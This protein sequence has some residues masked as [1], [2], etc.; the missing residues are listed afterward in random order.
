[1]FFT[2]SLIFVML[3]CLS[4]NINGLRSKPKQDMFFNQAKADILC[5]QETRWDEGNE[6]DIKKLWEGEVYVQNGSQ[7]SCG[8]ATMI[9]KGAMANVKCVHKDKKGRFIIEGKYKEV[10]LRLINIY[11]PNNESERK[12]FF[13]EVARWCNEDTIIIGDFN[14]ALTQIDVSK[15]N[16]FKNDASRR[17]LFK[18]CEEHNLTDV[19]RMWYKHKR[20]YSRKQM[21]KG[22]MKQTRIDLC[23]AAPTCVAKENKIVYVENSWSDHMKIEMLLENR[24]ELRNGGL[25]VYNASLNDD[26]TFKKKYV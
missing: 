3:H 12:E 18:L 9:K 10:N 14:V 26:E 19:W 17:V 6:K 23:L 8:V 21:V 2:L 20:E 16:V 13:E 1:M 4:L 15:N 7:K 11:A 22:T 24:K 25:W 5:L